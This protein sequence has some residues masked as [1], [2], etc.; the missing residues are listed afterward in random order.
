MN[1]IALA[2]FIATGEHLDKTVQ[3]PGSGTQIKEMDELLAWLKLSVDFIE[4]AVPDT[5]TEITRNQ[6]DSNNE[7]FNFI[8]DS[9]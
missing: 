2:I 4:D 5:T 9:E 6:N 1:L 8:L 7:I 3:N